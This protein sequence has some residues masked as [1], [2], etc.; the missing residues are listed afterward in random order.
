MKRD[1]ARTAYVD[2]VRRELH[3]M[4]KQC[5]MKSDF[6]GLKSIVDMHHRSLN[7]KTSQIAEIRKQRDNDRKETLRR[8]ETIR[9]KSDGLELGLERLRGTTKKLENEM[10]SKADVIETQKMWKKFEGYASY[11]D[12][13]QLY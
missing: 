10:P 11:E 6:I 7:E 12:Y 13:K 1:Y 4:I 8:I 9:E 3:E 5:T 2:K